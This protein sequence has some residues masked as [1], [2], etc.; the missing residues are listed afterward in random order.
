MMI[1]W[2]NRLLKYGK[3]LINMSDYSAVTAIANIMN[4][5]VQRICR[6]LWG[7]PTYCRGSDKASVKKKCLSSNDAWV[8]MRPF[9]KWE[10]G[11]WAKQKACC[12]PRDRC[13]AVAEL[14]NWA[15]S[16]LG[17]TL[18]FIPFWTKS[19]WIGE[20]R[21]AKGQHQDEEI[22]VHKPYLH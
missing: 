8:G 7:D 14:R 9:K 18:C 12:V 17:W 3:H 13:E 16:R 15:K 20:E 22:L 21:V 19:E 11:G 5:K 10:E 6:S 4:D 2:F 1:R